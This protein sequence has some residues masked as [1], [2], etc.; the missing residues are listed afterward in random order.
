MKRWLT[1][2]KI[3]FL[4]IMRNIF[5]VFF[6]LFFP[7]MLLG[8]YGIIYG[9]DPTPFYNGM[10]AIDATITIY[11][12]IVVAVSGVITL[13]LSIA[14]YKEHK[15]YK[16]IDVTPIQK[17]VIILIQM[18]CCVVLSFIGIGLLL[19]VGFTV[20]SLKI[21]GNIMMV[22]ISIVLSIFSLFS[23]GF[24]LA[25]V[26]KSLKMCNLLCFLTYFVMIFISGASIPVQLLPDSLLT[27]S[28]LFPL[29]HS[30]EV[31]NGAFYGSPISAYF[32]NII[33]VMAFGCIYFIVGWI[34][35]RRQEEN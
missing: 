29:F 10:G 23:L 18:L 33:T 32:G 21:E 9:N 11:I 17:E 7:V 30:I 16:R 4:L 28:K 35:Y 12:G 22:M 14:E 13:P 31:L 5:A 25:A 15:V 27:L 24:F 19:F 8:M 20:Y 26:S 34:S 2:F 6:T 1:I 3:E